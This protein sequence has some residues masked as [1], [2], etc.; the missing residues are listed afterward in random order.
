MGL[1]GNFLK[2]LLSD[3]SSKQQHHEQQ[4]TKRYVS[5]PPKRYTIEEFVILEQEQSGETW[6]GVALSE[7]SRLARTFYRG[8]YVKVDQY[9]F[10]EIFYTSNSGKT[11]FHAQCELDE[12]GKLQR[13]THNYYPGQVRDPA[14]AIIEKMNQQFSFC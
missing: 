4:Q 3:S 7:M 10:L 11:T 5:E 13:L 9:N 2:A 14:D 12:N 8:K 6:H 1:L